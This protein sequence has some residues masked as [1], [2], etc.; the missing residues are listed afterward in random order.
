MTA[1]QNG[2]FG[3]WAEISDLCA[4]CNDYSLDPQLLEDCL[5]MASGVLYNLAPIKYPGVGEETVR[6]CAMR[7]GYDS[8]PPSRRAGAHPGSGWWAEHGRPWGAC[9]CN[10]EQVGCYSIPAVR[11]GAV[12]I[13]EIVEV[14]IDGEVLDPSRYRVDN[15]DTLVRLPD[16]DGRNPGWHCC[17]RIDLPDTEPHTWSVKYK[18]GSEP[19]IGGVRAAASL[20]CQLALSMSPRDGV[21][22]RL[23]RRVQSITRQNMTAAV[24]DPFTLFDKGLTGLAEVDLWLASERAKARGGPAMFVNPET[25]ARRIRRVGT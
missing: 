20:G 11:L 23:P 9:A 22:C 7:R 14:K 8:G 18:F 1:P 17:Q 16:A 10:H 15:W 21:N 13:V 19:P 6:P 25:A 3:P 24:I 4:P 2:P 5:L 12:P